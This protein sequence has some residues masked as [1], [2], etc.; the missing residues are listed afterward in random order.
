MNKQDKIVKEYCDRVKNP[1]TAIRA[2]CVSCMGGYVKEIKTCSATSCPLYPFR[3]GSNPLHGLS[4]KSPNNVLIGK[5][6]NDYEE[7]GE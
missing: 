5:N 3:F 7:K 1:L 2:F 6:L 4:G